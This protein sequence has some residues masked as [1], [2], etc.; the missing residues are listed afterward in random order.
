[1]ISFNVKS[2]IVK[3]K[4]SRVEWWLPGTGGWGVDVTVKRETE[5]SCVLM[6]L[7]S[8]PRL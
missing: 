7:T 1:M 2:R 3:L 6:E 5:M 4:N 8:A